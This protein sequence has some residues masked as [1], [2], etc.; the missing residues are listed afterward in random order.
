[1][2]FI[3]LVYILVFNSTNFIYSMNAD[4]NINN[5]ISNNQDQNEIKIDIDNDDNDLW[6]I[7]KESTIKWLISKDKERGLQNDIKDIFTGFGN[8]LEIINELKDPALTKNKAI[9]NMLGIILYNLYKSQ[10]EQKNDLEKHVNSRS[11]KSNVIQSLVTSFTILSFIT[12][13]IITHY[14]K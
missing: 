12:L 13:Y 3:V 8:G 7:D 1:M 11:T 6:P 9:K 2:L 10:D 14:V 4:N 5:N